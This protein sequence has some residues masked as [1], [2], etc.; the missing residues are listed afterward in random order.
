MADR[1]GPADHDL[2]RGLDCVSDCAVAHVQRKDYDRV[3]SFA[4]V[5][6][7]QVLKDNAWRVR[8]T[9]N[10]NNCALTRRSGCNYSVNSG[11]LT[12][13]TSSYLAGQ[14]FTRLQLQVL[15]PHNKHSC[16]TCWA[17]ICVYSDQRSVAAG[18]A[19][20]STTTIVHLQGDQAATRQS[21][22]AY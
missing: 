21:T 9:N 18:D 1:S 12:V 7:V 8:N 16:F 2:D 6:V 17:E 22:A 10:N 19:T 20:P 3:V 4:R 14:I 13:C 15:Q 11:K 5:V